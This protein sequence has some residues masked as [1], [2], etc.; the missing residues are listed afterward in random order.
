MTGCELRAVGRC[1]VMMLAASI[2]PFLTAGEL[3][4]PTGPFPIGRTTL[5]WVDG[6]RTE[7]NASASPRARR[8]VLVYLWYPAATRIDA[9]RRA[10]YMPQLQEV[11]TYEDEHYGKGSTA[12]EYGSLYPALHEMLT[13]ATENAPVSDVS[14]RYPVLVFSH[15]GGMEVLVYSTIIEELASH[16]YVVAAV[17]HPYDGETI[18]FPDGHVVTEAGWDGDEKRT[19]EERIRFHRHREEVDAVDNSFVLD[20]LAALNRG[21]R[22]GAVSF[23]GRLDVARSGALGHSL[24]GKVAIR[25][26]HMDQRWKA[27][28]DL[29][30]GADS[31]YGLVHQPVMAIVGDRAPTLETGEAD[32]H[33]RKRA[34]SRQKFLGTFRKPFAET[35]G[36]D[37]LVLV[38][39]PAFSHFS[40]YDIP[41][42]D[43]EVPPWRATP[44][45]WSSNLQ[46]I[47]QLSLAFFDQYLKG[48]S[49]RLEGVA[50]SSPVVAIE[51]LRPHSQP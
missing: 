44:E 49:G 47:R 16:G 12:T 14:R 51:P 3:L 43:A 34:A 7:E 8:E 27:C 36:P 26:C 22:S 13:H 50:R 23:R 11:Q 40:Y 5:H 28:A 20:Q 18:I 2:S 45:Q 42:S 19:A 46:I 41:T 9:R 31:D 17:E 25:S 30:G 33:L 15:G 29:D 48:L 4:P 37:D 6:S 39:S 10:A 32:E 35:R 1:A 24:G 38:S 21:G